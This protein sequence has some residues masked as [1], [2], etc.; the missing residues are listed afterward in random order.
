MGAEHFDSRAA[1]WDD[2]PAK[3][4]QS[5]EVAAGVLA[6]VPVDGSTRVLEYGAGTGLV[7]QALADQVGP[8][9]LAD[10]SWGMRQVLASKVG[11]GALPTGSRVWE[12]DLEHDAVPDERFDLVVSSMVLHHVHDLAAV[13]AGFATLLEPGGHVAIADLDREDGSFH[14]HLHDFDGHHGFDRGQLR[15]ALEEAGFTQV[16]TTDAGVIEKEDTSYPVF[17]AVGRR[18]TD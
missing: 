7:S 11:S 5:G 14:A 12:L 8:L 3:V 13:L 17:L 2:D 15:A 1:T 18:R 9:T 10:N 16:S 6:A 4:R